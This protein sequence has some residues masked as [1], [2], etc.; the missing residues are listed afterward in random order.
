M[1]LEPGL[2]NPI[3]FTNALCLVERNMR[4]LGLPLCSNIVTPPISANERPIDCQPLIASP[5]CPY[6]PLNQ[7]GVHNQCRRH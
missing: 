6:L 4:G 1:F 3:R 5:F 2:L 7:M